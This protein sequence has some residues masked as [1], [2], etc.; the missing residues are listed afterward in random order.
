[1]PPSK[2]KR[3]NAFEDFPI[4]EEKPISSVPTVAEGKNTT[5]EIERIERLKPSEM[6]PDRFQPRRLLPMHIRNSF[7]S[8]KIDCYQAASE[9]IKFGQQDSGVKGE[10]ERLISLGNSFDEH[11]Q[12]KAITGSWEKD[13]NGN[14]VFL[15]ETGERRFWAACLQV[16]ANHIKE[17]PLLRVEVID[18]PTRQR[19]VLEN[20]HAETPSAVEQ[21]CEVA[22]LILAEL[23][24]S[25][26]EKIQDDYDFFRLARS[27]RMPAGLWDRITP[28]MQLTRPR[29]VQLLN[30]L[31]M[32]SILLEK[33]DR[34]RLP[35]RV[36][37]EIL[38]QPQRNWDSLIHQ[39]IQ[40]SLTSDEIADQIT[41]DNTNAE[42]R[43]TSSPKAPS[44]PEKNANRSI[45][46]FTRVFRNI[47]HLEQSEILDS[48]ADDLFV[49]GQAESAA[50]LLSELLTLIQ[51]RL[52]R[53]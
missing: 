44:T 3:F 18:H 8:G 50:E 41:A 1:M 2:K 43:K 34:F 7:F 37:R 5:K 39:S 14:Y 11:G 46:K 53:K 30:I 52:K 23:G 24:M 49:S 15:I 35:E 17:E 4:T 51:A 45:R 28:I 27:Q 6:M 20:R 31:Q 38:N 33:A 42:N 12:I 19:Q 32:P 48:V 26:D 16:S 9:W 10:I 22:A 47:D 21:A 29:M 40:N 25:P 13:V 36:L